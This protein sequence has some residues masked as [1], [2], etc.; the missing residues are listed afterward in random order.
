MDNLLMVAKNVID[1]AGAINTGLDDVMP[2]EIEEI[3]KFHAKGAAIAA[4]GAGWI[5]GAGGVLAVTI[6]AGFIWSMY[7]RINKTLGLKLAD[8]ILKTLASGVATNLAAAAIASIAATTLFSFLP[9]I[10]NVAA[11]AIMGGVCYALTKASGLVY[12]KILVKVFKSKKDIE[13]YSSKDFKNVAY[14]VMK[15]EDM[16]S[17]MKEAKNEFKASKARGEIKK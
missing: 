4:I 7:A 1:I 8:N 9:G 14:S 5:P 15:D 12:L 17:V 16:K 2:E 11:S 10:G 13:S 3:V 6:S